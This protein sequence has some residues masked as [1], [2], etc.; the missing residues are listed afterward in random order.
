[1]LWTCTSKTRQNF[2]NA[3]VCQ[4]CSLPEWSMGRFIWGV[5]PN[6]SSESEIRVETRRVQRK[7]E[8]Q[9]SISYSCPCRR[10]LFARKTTRTHFL[11]QFEF[12]FICTTSIGKLGL[13]LLSHIIMCAKFFRKNSSSHMLP[14]IRYACSQ[15]F[16]RVGRGWPA[17]H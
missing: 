4:F 11:V 16:A 9:E 1:M 8:S 13:T 6:S 15:W 2:C 10:S 3:S 7:T 5:V 14:L 17:H 12:P